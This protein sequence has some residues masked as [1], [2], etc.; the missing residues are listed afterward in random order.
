M[1]DAAV[2]GVRCAR[3]RCAIT[4]GKVGR[5]GDGEDRAMV[6]GRVARVSPVEP[7]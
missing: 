6:A 1:H 5:V 2:S 4:Q 3:Q 7:L